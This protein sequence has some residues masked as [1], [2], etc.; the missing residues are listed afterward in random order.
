MTK[1]IK[2]DFLKNLRAKVQEYK[3]LHNADS[4]EISNFDY[5]KL[6]SDWQVVG[7]DINLSV[8]KLNEIEQDER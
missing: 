1:K 3:E 6:K 4:A 5:N 2:N 8:K 7:D